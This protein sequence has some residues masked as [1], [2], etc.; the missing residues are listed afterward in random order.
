[1]SDPYPLFSVFAFIGFVVALIP[2]PWHLQALNAGTC[3]YMFWASM[4]S[5]IQFVD[6]IVW[7][8]S[9]E[10]VAP[11]WCDICRFYPLHLIH[12]EIL[13]SVVG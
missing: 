7:H 2:L 1:M 3:L 5:L 13:T 4:S 10:K 12:S 9:I 11:I 6:S 8:N